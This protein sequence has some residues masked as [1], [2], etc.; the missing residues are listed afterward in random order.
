MW[1][2]RRIAQI[3][4]RAYQRGMSKSD[5]L[6]VPDPHKAL[7]AR[8][9]ALGARAEKEKGRIE[10]AEMKLE[11]A[12]RKLSAIERDSADVEAQLRL[13]RD[14]IRRRPVAGLAQF[15]RKNRQ[16]HEVW[17]CIQIAFK[18][19]D[20]SYTGIVLDDH[21]RALKQETLY[22]NVRMRLFRMHG[23]EPL[24]DSTFRSYL[25]RLKNEP[26]ELL[27]KHEG[28]W[29]LTE[30]ALAPD[31]MAAAGKEEIRITK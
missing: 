27:W 23:G 29:R 3:A 17:I 25:H 26:Y 4:T 6:S 22:K 11:R 18:G 10:L 12:R 31:R 1:Q 14:E 16:F 8:L 30:K 20:K 9:Q 28:R 15:T 5:H 13:L 7:M 24:K 19:S 21:P 2:K